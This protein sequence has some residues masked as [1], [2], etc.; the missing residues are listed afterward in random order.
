MAPPW[1][2]EEGV[3]IDQ[4]HE[5]AIEVCERVDGVAFEPSLSEEAGVEI[6]AKDQ[7][8]VRVKVYQ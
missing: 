3:S 2:G 6:W 8:E 5:F 4:H 1:D 7:E